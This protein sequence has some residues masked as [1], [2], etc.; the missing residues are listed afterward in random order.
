M[1]EN[2]KKT[3]REWKT[4]LLEQYSAGHHLA[5]VEAF[6]ALLTQALQHYTSRDVSGDR[7]SGACTIYKH[8]IMYF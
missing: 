7:L 4:I 8:K 6:V 5:R 3:A 1:K 2:A